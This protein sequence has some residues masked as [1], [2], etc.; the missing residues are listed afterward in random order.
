MTDSEIITCLGGPCAVARS[1]EVTQQ[2]V[3]A[4]KK[5]GISAAGRY[6]IKD[7]A[8]SKRFKLPKDFMTRGKADASAKAKAKS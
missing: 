5:R 4:W 2:V 6:M 8:R 3:S 7:L 1:L